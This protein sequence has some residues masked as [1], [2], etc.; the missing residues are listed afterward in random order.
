MNRVDALLSLRPNAEWVIQDEV[1]DWLDTKQ[2]QPTEEE[3]AAEI[4]RLQTEYDATEYQRKR[5]AEYPSI[6]DQLD[7][8]YH[9]GLDA[10][11]AAIQ[12]VKIKYPKVTS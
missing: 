11:K 1:I 8:L 2:T 9:G 10:W 5:A 7:L 3:I 6:P 4:V 12:T